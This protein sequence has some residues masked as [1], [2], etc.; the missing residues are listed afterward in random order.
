MRTIQ[1]YKMEW[2]LQF[3][4]WTAEEIDI[5]MT[6]VEQIESSTRFNPHCLTLPR[7]KDGR[8]PWFWYMPDTPDDAGP[9]SPS[10]EF[11]ARL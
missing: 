2:R 9:G 11:R 5:L 7:C 1:S 4:M 3:D 10:P 6:D 8:T